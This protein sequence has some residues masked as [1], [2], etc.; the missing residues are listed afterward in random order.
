MKNRLDKSDFRKEIFS[1][2]NKVRKKFKKTFHSEIERF[3]NAVF[4]AYKTCKSI[5]EK[6]KGDKQR[7]YIAA[8]LFN[9]LN[10]LVSS[11]HLLISGYVVSSGNLMRHFLESSAMA[12]LLSNKDLNYFERFEQEG[13]KFP[14]H[15]A[16]DYVSKN[17]D[18]LKINHSNWHNFIEIGRFYNSSN[19]ASAFALANMFHFS[20]KGTV[21]IGADFDPAK[22][23]PY[24][25]EIE[26][27]ISAANCLENITEGIERGNV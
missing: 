27:R 14:V 12:I 3:L 22:L 15:K 5:D 1:C 18:K 10:N 19:H 23:M 17:V 11:F 20:S 2:N 26:G 21:V 25:K 9:A 24:R 6:C 7:S 16:M 8:F 4:R 13:N